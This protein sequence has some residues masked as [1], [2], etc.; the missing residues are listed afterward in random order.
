VAGVLRGPKIAARRSLSTPVFRAQS[1]VTARILG[2]DSS[3]YADIELR[4]P[5]F[6]P[7]LKRFLAETKKLGMIVTSKRTT[8]FEKNYRAISSSTRNTPRVF[9]NRS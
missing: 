9:K 3:L 4:N 7:V 6:R 5:A 8:A 1:E 2:G